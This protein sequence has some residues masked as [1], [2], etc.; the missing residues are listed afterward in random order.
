[1]KKR[2]LIGRRFSKALVT[3]LDGPRCRHVICVCDCGK[4]FRTSKSNLY[5][6]KTKSCG[7][8]RSTQGGLTKTHRAEYFAWKG[9]HRRCSDTKAGSWLHYGGRGI[10]VCDRWASFDNFLADLG[11][12][13]S[14]DMSIDRIDVNGNYDPANCRWATSHTQMRN[15]QDSIVLMANGTSMHI[16]DWSKHLRIA[17]QTIRQRLLRGDSPERALRPT[18][19]IT[20]RSR[21]YG[22]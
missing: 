17:T 12:K 10:S 13:P 21:A 7:C 6:G 20:S 14:P 4:E 19:R 9:M 22:E 2:S 11:S 5:S 15:R 1:M 8:I 16:E 3:K 18:V